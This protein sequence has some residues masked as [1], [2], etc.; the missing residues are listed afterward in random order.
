MKGEP[1]S[2]NFKGRKA[3][4]VRASRVAR[5]SSKKRGT[6]LE[7]LL[8]RVLWGAGLHYQKNVDSLPGKPALVFLGPKVV[9]SC[10]GD[11]WHGKDWEECRKKPEG[12]HNVA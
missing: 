11:Y 4:S 12:G 8:R 7:L 9:V 10:D 2:P 6:K 1:R 5:G 3:I